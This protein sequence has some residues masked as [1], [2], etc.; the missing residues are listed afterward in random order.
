MLTW[1]QLG[2]YLSIVVTVF[3]GGV[4]AL[5]PGPVAGVTTRGV[6]LG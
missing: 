4:G 5:L 1:M 6:C 2:G 3:A